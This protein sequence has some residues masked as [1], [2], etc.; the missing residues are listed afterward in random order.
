[1]RYATIGDVS[2]ENCHPFAASDGGGRQWTLMHQGTIFDYHPTNAF[3]HTQKGD[4]DSERILL[5]LID[6]IND[7]TL[8]AGRALSE[9]ERFSVLE[10]EITKMSAG[11][12]LNLAVFDSEILYLHTNYRGTL[13][14]N[15]VEDGFIFCTVP[16]DDGDWTPH[17]LNTLCSYK[18]GKLLRT[19]KTHE[20]EYV[21]NEEDQKYLY[22]TFSGL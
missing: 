19:G 14:A 20:N 21:D 11:N 10:R 1:M 16:L 15:R 2:E 12:K 3:L 9:D 18:N 17:T 4:T 6:V 8:L 7:E 22:L 13:Y 5:F